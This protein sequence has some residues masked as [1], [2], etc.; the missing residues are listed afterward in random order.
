MIQPAAARTLERARAFGIDVTLLVEN[1][2]RTPEE[3][4]RRAQDLLDSVVALRAEARAWRERGSPPPGSVPP[5][6]G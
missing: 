2:R 1:L 3:R 6:R 5:D 4:V